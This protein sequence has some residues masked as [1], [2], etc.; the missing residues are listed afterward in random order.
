MTEELV[1]VFGDDCEAKDDCEKE[2]LPFTIRNVFIS[3]NMCCDD[4]NCTANGEVIG[5]LVSDLPEEFITAI[6]PMLIHVGHFDVPVSHF[7]VVDHDEGCMMFDIPQDV[8]LTP[9]DVEDAGLDWNEIA[10]F[11]AEW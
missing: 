11:W 2:P 3:C 1:N 8:Y 6:N 5:M 7:D 4:E 9:E 10:E